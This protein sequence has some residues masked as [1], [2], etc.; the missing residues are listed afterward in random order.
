MSTGTQTPQ[1]IGS[2]F[3]PF[4]PAFLSTRS[5]Q[6]Q[7]SLTSVQPSV[8]EFADKEAIADHDKAVHLSPNSAEIRYSR[9]IAKIIFGQHD[10]AITDFNEAIRLNPDYADAYYNRGTAKY[11]LGRPEE[12][13]SDFQIALT[14]AKQQGR[15]DIEVDVEHGLQR[16]RNIE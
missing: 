2:T 6:K 12:A 10:D 13:K 16:L 1:S 3:T 9:G 11:V 7:V 15:E 8:H 4:G 14:L 5:P